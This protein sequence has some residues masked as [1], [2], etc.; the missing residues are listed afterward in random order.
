ALGKPEWAAMGVIGVAFLLLFYRWFYMQHRFAS[1]SLDDWG[2]T[3]MVPLIAGWLAWQERERIARAGSEVFWPGLVPMCTG[4]MCY[5]FA[6]VVV[7]NHMIQGFSVILTL[8]GVVLLVLG[9]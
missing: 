5:L 1:S 7:P 6:L 3:Y 8:F 4:I 9:P 2:H